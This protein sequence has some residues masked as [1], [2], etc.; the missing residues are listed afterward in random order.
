VGGG[1]IFQPGVERFC[2]AARAG[3]VAV[4]QRA[5]A[6]MAHAFWELPVGQ[7]HEA[8]DN[9]A[10]FAVQAVRAAAAAAV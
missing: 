1:D 8:I 5:F 6:G 4:E 3:G 7:A 10:R 2:A 9:A